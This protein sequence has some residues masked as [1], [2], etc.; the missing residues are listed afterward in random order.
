MEKIAI[1]GE[2]D[3]QDLPSHDPH[4]LSLLDTSPEIG[5][6]P[7]SCILETND[8]DLPIAQWK[9]VKPALMS[10][11]VFYHALSRSFRNFSVVLSS[12][13]IP[14]NASETLS[15]LHWKDAMVDEMNALE[16][17]CTWELVDSPHGKKLV[18]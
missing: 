11:F 10:N 17:N 4:Q 18:G 2:G 3:H 14:R 9:C 12:V 8:L 7:S 1:G 5:N 16:K 13:F 6:P 15:Y